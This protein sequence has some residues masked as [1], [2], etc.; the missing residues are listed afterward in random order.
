VIVERTRETY[1][2]PVTVGED[3]T[4]FVLTEAST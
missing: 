3:L 1:Y 2:G 4:E